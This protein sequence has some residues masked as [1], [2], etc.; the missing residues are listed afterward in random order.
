MA[1]RWLFEPRT[2]R[3]PAE[4]VNPMAALFSNDFKIERHT[5]DMDLL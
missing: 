4:R 3:Q 1:W 5:D 2:L